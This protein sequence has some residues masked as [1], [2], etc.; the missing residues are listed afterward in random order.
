MAFNKKSYFEC[1]LNIFV[2]HTP[3]QFRAVAVSK[4]NLELEYFE[5]LH[6]DVRTIIKSF[7]I[8]VMT[9]RATRLIK[10]T[11]IVL[12]IGFIWQVTR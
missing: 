9:K 7:Y 12:Y 8:N 10:T 6:N 2:Q 5:I 1:N 11:V 3:T 4:I